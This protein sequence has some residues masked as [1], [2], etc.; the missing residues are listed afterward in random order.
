MV[1]GTFSLTRF[2]NACWRKFFQQKFNLKKLDPLLID[3]EKDGNSAWLYGPLIVDVPK[4]V[5]EITRVTNLKKRIL[6][7]KSDPAGLMKNLNLQEQVLLKPGNI[8]AT[9]GISF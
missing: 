4:C 9:G 5:V 8:L 1:A 2:E 6:K 3:W 7:R